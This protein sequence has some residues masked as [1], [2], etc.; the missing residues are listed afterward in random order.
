MRKSFYLFIFIFIL[1]L[2]IRFLLIL[3]A[4]LIQGE[5]ELIAISKTISLDRE[6]ISLPYAN[7]MTCHPLFMVYLV[8][9]GAAMFGDNIL[10][11]RFFSFITGVL[12]SLCVYLLAKRIA[13]S[14]VGII[15]LILS[16]FNVYHLGRSLLAVEE[17]TMLFLAAFSLWMVVEVI[18]NK[19]YRLLILCGIALSLGYLTDMKII[20]FLPIILTY[21]FLYHKDILKRKEIYVLILLPLTIVFLDIVLRYETIK[22]VLL[23]DIAFISIS[24]VG[25]DFYLLRLI[26]FISG[27]DY[28]T[29]VSWEIPAMSILDGVLIIYGVFCSLKYLKD[30]IIRFMVFIFIAFVGITTFFP[31]GEFW[32]AGLSLWPGIYLASYAYAEAYKK[33]IIYKFLILFS[34]SVIVGQGITLLLNIKGINI[35]PD[36]FSTTVDYDVDLMKWYYNKGMVQEALQE[37]QLAVTM[38]PNDQNVRSFLELCMDRIKKENAHDRGCFH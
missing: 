31:R 25:I 36:R 24:R 30:E 18:K 17:A 2:V 4:P 32:W 12:S 33:R 3:N 29:T 10:G 27:I 26:S 35:P 1:A 20:L 6:N 8:K 28:R 38:C 11:Y 37:A 21:F 7:V 9:L 34:L 5:K 14:A 22:E 13:G 23:S 15:A 19:S 16:S